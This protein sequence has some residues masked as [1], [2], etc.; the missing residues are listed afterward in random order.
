MENIKI[1]QNMAK[2]FRIL[3]VEDSKALQKQVL[4]FLGKFF[5]EIYVASDGFEGIELYKQY[6]PDLIITDLTMPKMNGHD[7]IREIKKIN[8]DIEIIIISAH[9]DS[10]NLMTSFHIGVSDFIQ[11]PVTIP[12]MITV[13]LKVLS[14]LA[15]KKEQIENLIKNSMDSG[16]NDILNFIYQGDLKFNLVNNY[17]GVPII[18]EGK[19]IQLNGDEITV[20]TS[21]DQLTAINYEKMTI[22]DCP[23]VSENIFCKLQ[24][25]DL[26]SYEVKLQKEKVF[27]P[28]IKYKKNSMIE[29]DKF[30]K[31]YLIKDDH[32]IDIKILEISVKEI[33]F[34]ISE[35]ILLSKHDSIELNLFLDKEETLFQTIIFK[36]EEKNEFN[37][38][39]SFIKTT[40]K[41]QKILERYIY[42]REIE[43]IEE[44]KNLHLYN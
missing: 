28:T 27:L 38:I 3:L 22:I 13:F 6:K 15:R 41:N 29:P 44:F 26:N 31:A 25:F 23:Q 39:T 14:N 20:K 42:Q 5:K 35:E 11:K 16:N 32:K 21:F 9:S 8:P 19:I 2:E 18:N 10:D 40:P 1:L 24:F 43:L 36:I 37:I 30:F 4:L 34:Q 7:M 33:K 17:K 12:K